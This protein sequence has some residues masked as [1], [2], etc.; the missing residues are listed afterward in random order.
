ML[1]RRSVS[2]I[3]CVHPGVKNG[4]PRQARW[5]LTLVKRFLAAW[6]HD[7]SKVGRGRFG[8]HKSTVLEIR[9]TPP[10]SLFMVAYPALRQWRFRPYLGDGKPDL[11]GADIIFRVP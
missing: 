4:I 1:R 5:Q 2:T 11:F 8:G 9:V 3:V 6:I 7:S 10:I